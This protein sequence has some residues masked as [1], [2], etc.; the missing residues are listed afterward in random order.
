MPDWKC[1]VEQNL[2]SFRIASDTKAE[3]ADELSSYLEDRYEEMLTSGVSETKALEACLNEI[4]G[5]NGVIRKIED[6]KGGRT[7]MNRR[8]RTLWL[9]GFVSLAAASILMMI[10]EFV[11][12]FRNWVRV[13]DQMSFAYV[14]WMAMLPLCGA[15][16]AFISRRGEGTTR[17]RLTAGLFPSLAMMC[18]FLLVLPF[19]LLVNRNGYVVSH[20]RAFIVTAM[21]W[22][23]GPGLA[24]LIGA[25]PFCGMEKPADVVKA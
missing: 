10:L 17:E 12:Y 23:F 24:L 18:V 8:T 15:A 19:D 4:G 1:L 22:V 25:V 21:L 20:P 3:V 11:F 13:S 9:P 16:G 7:S 6:A 5:L 2:K 14:L